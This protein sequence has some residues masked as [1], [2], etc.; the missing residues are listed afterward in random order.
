MHLIF[1]TAGNRPALR[2]PQE[3]QTNNTNKWVKKKKNIDT[4]LTKHKQHKETRKSQVKRET[5]GGY[6]ELK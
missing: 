2:K 6:T 1:A 4:N 3:K 5:Q